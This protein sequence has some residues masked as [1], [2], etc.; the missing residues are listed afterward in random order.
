MNLQAFSKKIL[1]MIQDKLTNGQRTEI[2]SVPKNN[3]TIMQGLIIYSS[4]SNISPTI[5]LE[6]FYALYIKNMPL[7]TIVD[8]IWDLYQKSIPQKQIDMSFFQNYDQVKERIFY[9]LINFEKNKNRLSDMPHLHFWDLAIIFCY[10]F[11]S[12]ELGDGTIQINNSHLNHWGVQVEDLMRD[13]E[14]NTP[15]IFPHIFL[16]INTVMKQL[17]PDITLDEPS[18]NSMYILTNSIK[19]NGA[20][21]ILYP[22][23]LSQI[24]QKM[25]CDFYIIPSSIHE[26]LILPQHDNK[27]LPMQFLH[28]TISLINSSDVEPEDILSDYPFF[29]DIKKKLLVQLK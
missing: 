10:A 13:A 7:S 26:L 22:H 20:T 15:R 12:D 21:A 6:G 16:S 3:G 25:M 11:S 24:A 8:K 19:T 14:T 27:E 5:Y 29:Y 9:K 1:E 28:Q 4:E 17:M 23:V 2:I 18:D